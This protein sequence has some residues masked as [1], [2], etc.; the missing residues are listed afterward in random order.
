MKDDSIKVK[1]LVSQHD[2]VFNLLQSSYTRGKKSNYNKSC[3]RKNWSE[4]WLIPVRVNRVGIKFQKNLVYEIAQL[5]TNHIGEYT[6]K[7]NFINQGKHF[8]KFEKC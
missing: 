4:V 8:L 5:Y 1:K 6:R 3:I 2:T 7:I